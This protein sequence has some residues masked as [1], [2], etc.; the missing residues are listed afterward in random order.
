MG[1]FEITKLLLEEYGANV[2]SHGKNGMTAFQLACLAYAN[3]GA[4]A[5]ADNKNNNNNS[6]DDDEKDL[7]FHLLRQ[8]NSIV[9]LVNHDN[10]NDADEMDNVDVDGE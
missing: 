2:G 7:V 1:H 5:G 3:A 10:D 9:H 8:H 6:C 4:G